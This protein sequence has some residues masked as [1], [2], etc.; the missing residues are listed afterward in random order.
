M[1]MSVFRYIVKH[2][3]PLSILKKIFFFNEQSGT[4]S[5]RTIRLARECHSPRPSVL[6][7]VPSFSII[8]LNRILASRIG[9]CK[10]CRIRSEANRT[11]LMS[12][13]CSTAETAIGTVGILGLLHYTSKLFYTIGAKM[14]SS[15]LHS[16]HSYYQ[17]RQ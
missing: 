13:W 10:A 3:R 7:A 17:D 15:N 9:V 11:W 4:A 2:S 8:L 16:I 14:Q 6:E 5:S 1:Q 12:E